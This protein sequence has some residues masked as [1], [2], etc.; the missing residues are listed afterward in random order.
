VCQRQIT[1]EKKNR[2]R[3][4]LYCPHPYKERETSENPTRGGVERI[5]AASV[6]TPTVSNSHQ[7][8]M[9]ASKAW[10]RGSPR[11]LSKLSSCAAQSALLQPRSTALARCEMAS[12][13][14]P[15]KAAMQARS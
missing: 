13:C 12:S 3:T 15:A 9:R 8:P 10:N 2:G 6:F 1:D 7:F 11:R 4:R 14:I 5:L